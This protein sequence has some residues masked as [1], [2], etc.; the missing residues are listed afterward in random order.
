MAC[1]IQYHETPQWLLNV[2]NDAHL[3]N[4]DRDA[5]NQ[6]AQRPWHGFNNSD[7]VINRTTYY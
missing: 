6:A 2:L 1:T 4:G 3:S 5:Q 7:R